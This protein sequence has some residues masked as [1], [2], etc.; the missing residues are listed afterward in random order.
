MSYNFIKAPIKP[1][2]KANSKLSEW[3]EMPPKKPR[4]NKR[5]EDSLN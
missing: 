5:G 2:G 4:K 1:S 3:F